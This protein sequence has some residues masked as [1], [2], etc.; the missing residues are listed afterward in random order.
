MLRKISSL[1]FVLCLQ[2]PA[3]LA[4]TEPSQEETLTGQPGT[5][6]PGP[7]G[8]TQQQWGET[9]G[10]GFAVLSLAS[11]I[12]SSQ[13]PTG[14]KMRWGQL[15][16]LAAG[17]ALVSYWLLA[18][19]N[20]ELSSYIELS[21]PE[22]KIFEGEPSAQKRDRSQAEGVEVFPLTWIF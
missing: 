8:E 7:S 1:V 14:Q 10:A 21:Q 22:V 11:F 16:I 18:P 2:M 3:A 6:R 20:Q 4:G 5:N 17:G 12:H 19:E 9:L 15:G 13:V